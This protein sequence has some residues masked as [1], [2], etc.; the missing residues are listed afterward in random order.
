[1]RAVLNDI[2]DV[3]FEQRRW[4]EVNY[5]RLSFGLQND[6]KSTKI[7][8]GNLFD[9]IL[10]DMSLKLFFKII[11]QVSRKTRKFTGGFEKYIFINYHQSSLIKKR[12][13]TE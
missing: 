7:S 13:E 9:I 4:D 2:K 3:S 8:S 1:M 10:N 6:R 5:T 12:P 11:L